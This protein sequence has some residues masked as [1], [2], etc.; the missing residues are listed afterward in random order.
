MAL[1]PQRKIIFIITLLTAIISMLL[2]GIALIKG[3]FGPSSGVGA[4]FCESTRDW[5]IKQQSNT[6]SNIGFIVIGIITG[7][8]LSGNQF[9]HNANTLTRTLFLP[10][11]FS[12]FIV[13]LGPGS[14]AM[15]A[16]ETAL[17]GF[18]DMLS[19][20]L[21]A[22]FTSAYAIQ[23]FFAKG[24]LLFVATFAVVLAICLWANF[25]HYEII[26]G[27]FGNTAFA[28][29]I[30]VTCIFE[31]L[32][33]Y[34][35]NIQREFKWGLASLALVLIA[36]GIWN[37]SKNGSDYCD[38]YSPVQGHAIWHLLDAGSVYCLF[39]FYVSEHS[40]TQS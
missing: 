14:M 27:F 31:F 20:Y 25:Q 8:Q 15:H 30:T 2:F 39:R 29:F 10:A 12:S 19:M 35:R 13:L 1:H 23:R 7:W 4:V 37:L 40:P 36:L 18:F 22:S 3:W 21:I 24:A 32:N 38:P 9:S 11:F 17:G 34:L 5:L 16:T 33:Q 26:F 6:L 28:F